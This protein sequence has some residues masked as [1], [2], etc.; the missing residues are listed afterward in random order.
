LVPSRRQLR[1][2]LANKSR[3][4]LPSRARPSAVMHGECR[5]ASCRIF[6]GLVSIAAVVDDFIDRVMHN[7]VLNA[8]AAVDEKV[9]IG[10]EDC[11]GHSIMRA[12]AQRRCF[13]EASIC[14]PQADYIDRV[15]QLARGSTVSRRRLPEMGQRAAEVKLLPS[16]RRIN[17]LASAAGSPRSRRAAPITPRNSTLLRLNSAA[18]PAARLLN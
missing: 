8:N 6:S 11:V 9:V 1:V 2:G 18:S 14:V 15:A 3:S 13:R 12:R 5:P 16:C 4:S 17:S 7:P 10:G